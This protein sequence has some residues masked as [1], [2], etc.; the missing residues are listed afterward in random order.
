MSTKNTNINITVINMNRR[1]AP[2][3]STKKVE[4]HTPTPHCRGYICYNPRTRQNE[5][6]TSVEYY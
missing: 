6:T 5:Y 4:T 2:R 1:N 3:A